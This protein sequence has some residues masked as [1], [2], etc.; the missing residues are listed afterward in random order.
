M[1]RC[2]N[3]NGLIC[4]LY[5]MKRAINNDTSSIIDY[6]QSRGSLS[7]EDS[8]PRECHSWYLFGPNDQPGGKAEN[9]ICTI[10]QAVKE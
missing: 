3:W 4:N 6:I 10:G 2:L 1:C 9:T 5:T 8:C 7:A